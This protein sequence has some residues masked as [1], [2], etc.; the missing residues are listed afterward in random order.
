MNEAQRPLS[1]RAT[2]L[3]AVYRGLLCCVLGAAAA[4]PPLLV[5]ALSAPPDRPVALRVTGFVLGFAVVTL[6]MGFPR[7]ARRGCV[8][9]AGRLLD[10]G[11]PEPLESPGTGWLDRLRTSAWLAAHMA[12]GCV[13]SAGVFV[14]LFAGAA[15]PA[16]W[17]G[18]GG[19]MTAFGLAVDVPSGVGGVWT[20]LAG[21][22]F[23]LL[24]ALL[25]AGGAATLRRLAPPLL[26]HRAA[27][28]L[29]AVERRMAVLAQR[30]RLAQ[31]LHDSIGHT[32]TASTI[33]AALAQ[34]LMDRDPVAARRALDSIEETSR[35]AADDLDHVLGVLREERPATARPRPTLADLSPLAERVRGAGAELTVR[36]AGDLTGV[37]ATVSREAYRIVQE[38]LTNALRHGDPG[39]IGLR[40]AVSAGWLEAE[41]TNPCRA[42]SAS[43]GPTGGE[44]GGPVRQGHG[45]EGMTER[46]RLLRGELTSGPGQDGTHWRLA[47]RIP[48]RSAP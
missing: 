7:R 11:L 13:V 18:G 6:A 9:L 31:E 23:V 41:L 45:L 16:V 35:A 1:G 36:T 5:A 29:A 34:E 21:A 30:N 17:L 24:G 19:G 37:P 46:V 8:A 40:L 2:R 38:G 39:P 43:D 20:P 32:L 42:A 26:G 25:A 14:C 22:G 48:L 10:A 3:S 47:T 44:T 12:V 28:R 4:L 15:F 33:Q 27:E